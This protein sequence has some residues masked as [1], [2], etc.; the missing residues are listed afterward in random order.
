MIGQEINSVKKAQNLNSGDCVLC[1]V[2]N[3]EA[4]IGQIWN[5][6]NKD[7]YTYVF[8]NLLDGSRPYDSR[9][10]IPFYSNYQYLINQT[11]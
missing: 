5:D 2:Y 6:K 1:L 7:G 8:Q 9:F 4:T 3:N 10:D 11:L